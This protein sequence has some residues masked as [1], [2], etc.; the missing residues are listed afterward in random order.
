MLPPRGWDEVA[1]DSEL[2]ALRREVRSLRNDN[3]S[4]RMEAMTD[5]IVADIARGF[6]AQTQTFLLALPVIWIF[7]TAVL[8]LA[9]K[10][11]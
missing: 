1:A 6:Q 2:E 9:A 5:R 11:L 3:M 4:L 8:L 7:F 10:L